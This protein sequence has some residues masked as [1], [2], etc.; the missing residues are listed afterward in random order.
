MIDYITLKHQADG[1]PTWDAFLGIILK[2]SVERQNWQSSE[3]I[4]RTLEGS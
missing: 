2:A 3:L 1:T 4:Q